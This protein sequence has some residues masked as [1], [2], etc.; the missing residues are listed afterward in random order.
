MRFSPRLVLL[1]LCLVAGSA[2][3]QK[4]VVLEIDGDSSG[5][6]RTQVEGAL[7]AAGSVEVIPL[8]SYVT[9]ASRKKL[10]GAAAMTP[11]GV[12]RVGRNLTFDAA[13]GGEASGN[14]YHV[15]IWDRA[16]QEL[17]TK[18][19]P[20]KRGQ[21]SEDFA[22]KLARAITAAAEQGKAR[23]PSGGGG[24]DDSGDGSTMPEVDL[25]GG[26]GNGNGNTS[27]DDSGDSGGRT[28]GSGDR[29][30][31]L[32][33]ESRKKKTVNGPPMF[34]AL[35]AGTTT[36]RSQCLRPGVAT[37]RAYDAATT[38]PVGTVIDFTAG[39]PY[40]GLG[41]AIEFFPLAHFDNKVLQGFGVLGNFAYGASLTRI[42]DDSSQGSGATKSVT[43]TDLSWAA[44]LAWRFHFA[45]GYGEPQAVGYVGVRG[46]VMGRR[47]D[48]D[49]T[50]GTA[51]PSSDRD[52]F[53]V[54]GLDVSIPVAKYFRVEGGVSYFLSPKVGAEQIIGYGNLQDPTGG[55]TSTG[56]GFEG[57]FA[58][59]IW[60]PLGWT[61]KVKYNA[62]ADH[63]W[64]QGQKWTTCNDQQCGG[65][66]EES[67]VSI[68]WGVTGS[69]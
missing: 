57:G 8:K 67:F 55:V 31:D 19:L 35:L 13:V 52:A 20:I 63:Y 43:S 33:G 25:S 15:I 7:K 62:F 4:V 60:G 49:P 30:A 54:L 44:Q 24:G 51:L 6:L 3:A 28:G 38:K 50:A 68:F 56:F 5:K 9:V 45:I 12:S 11:A 1:A 27:T 18:D 2:F 21:L 26:N 32:E 61:L 48:I 59:D 23:N 17:W 47:F 66:A 46:G 37:C 14:S 34:K 10:H 39:V 58:G 22:G 53:G 29:D 42:V 65:A 41:L 64:G 16:G 69:I 36:W 40:L